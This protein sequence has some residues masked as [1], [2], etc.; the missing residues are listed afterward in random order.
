MFYVITYALTAAGGFGMILLMSR[1]G[2]EAEK[3]SDYK[4]L[5]KKSP[6]FALM[7]MIIMFSMAG[8]PPTVGFYAKLSVLQQVVSVD[9]V[10][11]A[12]AAVFFSIIG[13]YYYLRVIKMIYFDVADEDT[14]A[15]PQFGL[16]P[17]G[18]TLSANALVVLVLGVFPGQL[19][20]LCQ[21]AI[22]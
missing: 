12:V 10:W 15:L 9:L 2:F 4:G 6:W 3:I 20:V 19:M 11:L 14:G 16:D 1:K 18:I 13:A 22:G 17:A 5:A 7:M 21:S 8:V